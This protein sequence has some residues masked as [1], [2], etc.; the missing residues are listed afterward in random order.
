MDKHIFRPKPSA[1]IWICLAMFAFI[2]FFF[3]YS[4]KHERNYFLMVMLFAQFAVCF[5]ISQI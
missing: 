1:W 5:R 2:I 4:I 3:L